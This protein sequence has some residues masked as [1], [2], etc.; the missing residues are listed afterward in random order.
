MQECIDVAESNDDL[1][2]VEIKFDQDDYLTGV[3]PGEYTITFDVTT[4]KFT[5][6]I[7]QAVFK[8]TLEDPCSPDQ[9]TI[10]NAEISDREV[11]LTDSD[12]VHEFESWFIVTPTFCEIE[13]KSIV[14][15]AIA[16]FVVLDSAQERYNIL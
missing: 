2:A 12:Q 4:D 10:E 13:V 3:A 14:D 16:D 8:F 1:D 11:T 5:D 6:V 9:I 15:D 7:T